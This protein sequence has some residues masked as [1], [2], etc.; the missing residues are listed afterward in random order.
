[1]TNPEIQK[2]SLQIAFPTLPWHGPVAQEQVVFPA[3]KLKENAERYLSGELSHVDPEQRSEKYNTCNTW[4]QLHLAVHGTSVER[5]AAILRDGAL[6][7][8]AKL[9]ELKPD[10]VADNRTLL[11]DKL[12]IE[13]G[14]HRYVFLNLGRVHP[15][16]VHPVY[17]L[18]PNRIIEEPGTAVALREIVHF[19]ALV[20]DEAIQFHR[21]HDPSLTEDVV[22]TRN[23]EAAREFFNNTFAGDAFIED[24][25]PRFLFK[26]YPEQTK[27]TSDIEYPGTKLGMRRMG[28]EV[29]I[30]NAW[31]GPQVTVPGSIDLSQWKPSVLITDISRASQIES[32]LRA[33]GLSRDR[34]F[35]IDHELPTYERRYRAI[36]SYEAPLN[37]GTYVNLALRDLALLARHNRFEQDFASSMVGWKS[38]LTA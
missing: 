27:F 22:K 8:Y 5:A 37:T 12:D 26:K 28:H 4:A 11:T 7:S 32:K 35:R 29:T 15:T 24:I 16:D 25:F 31:E 30:M 19:G 36:G 13:L 2:P 33:C 34:I 10:C 20:S 21:K 14:L 38:R 17:F 1:M 6:H 9:Q 18:F 3:E 23:S